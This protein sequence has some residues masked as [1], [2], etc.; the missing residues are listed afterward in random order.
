MKSHIPDMN[1]T[2][3]QKENS[4][5][6]LSGK[7]LFIK[8]FLDIVLS[9]FTLI[10][11]L[12]L[13][14]FFTLLIV[15][16]D[17]GAFLYRQERIGLRGRRF[18][19]FKFRTMHH[20]AESD[21]PMLSSDDDPRVTPIGRFMRR[22]KFDEIPN[23][24]NVLRGEMTI[25]GPRP[26]REYYL[27]KMREINRDTDLLKEVKPGITCYGQTEYGYASTLEQ[28]MERLPYE[29]EYVKRPSL[30]ADMKIMF[31]TLRVLLSGR[32]TNG[33]SVKM[34]SAL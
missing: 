1:N 28:M 18:R 10:I 29:L 9:L 13:S 11:T 8:R 32:T 23:F 31:R 33:S 26:E 4:L 17:R 27:E 14:L 12:P 3:S 6:R 25:V 5:R 7:H 20:N 30:K 16:H 24:I 21:G 34:Q 22:H 2:D 15:L 19:L